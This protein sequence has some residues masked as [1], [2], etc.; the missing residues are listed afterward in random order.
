MPGGRARIFAAY[1]INLE[2]V[3]LFVLLLLSQIALQPAQLRARQAGRLADPRFRP[4]QV[5]VKVG[6]TGWRGAGRKR[7][8]TLVGAGLAGE[9][10]AGAGRLGELLLEQ[11]LLVHLLLGP[12]ADEPL[13]ELG[14]EGGDARQLRAARTVARR[15]GNVSAPEIGAAWLPLL[16]VEI[17]VDGAPEAEQERNRRAN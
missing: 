1:H 4:A 12:M 6:R 17:T 8:R 16:L 3:F 7:G 5:A 2:R 14:G 13:L 9:A 15:R 10:V 11:L